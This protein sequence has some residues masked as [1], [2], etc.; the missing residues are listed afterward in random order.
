MV[1]GTQLLFCQSDTQME[2]KGKLLIAADQ[3]NL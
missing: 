1:V 2:L 3:L